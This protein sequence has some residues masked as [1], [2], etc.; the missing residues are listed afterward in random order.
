MKKLEC[1][2]CNKLIEN[3]CYN[4][5]YGVFCPECWNKVPQKLKDKMFEKTLIDLAAIGKLI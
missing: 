3:G 4:T 1:K 5:P 2:Q